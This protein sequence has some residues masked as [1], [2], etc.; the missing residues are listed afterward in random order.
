MRMWIFD[1]DVY[2]EFINSDDK[3]YR[4]SHPRHVKMKT[5]DI[6]KRINKVIESGDAL[7]MAGKTY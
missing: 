6:I 4:I 7:L 2:F 5:K 1:T 3:V